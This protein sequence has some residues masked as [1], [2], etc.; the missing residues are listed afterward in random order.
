[1]EGLKHNSHSVGQNCFHLVWKVKYAYSFLNR[2]HLKRCVEGTIQL[3]CL[4]KGWEIY[5]LKVMPDH[6]HLFISFPP[7]TA[8]AYVFAILK[9]KTASALFRNFPWLKQIFK[10]GHFWSPGKFYRSVGN[11]TYDVIQNY[12]KYSQGSWKTDF[13][14]LPSYYQQQKLPSFVA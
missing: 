1:M 14:N 9:A 12:I 10:T 7:A 13:S 6:I 8:P 5:E 4:Q 3:L 2:L 11:V